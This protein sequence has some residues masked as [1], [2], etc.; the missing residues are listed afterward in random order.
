MDRHVGRVLDALH[1]NGL[2]S[3]TLVIYA[4]DH[5]EQARAHGAWGKISM[6]EDS[7]RVPLLIRGPG[8]AAGRVCRHP[9]SLLDLYPTIGE[10]MGLRPPDF[11]RGASLLD[12]AGGHGDGA[13]RPDHAIAECHLF[14]RAASFAVRQ[15]HWKLI[16]TLGSQPL[17]FNLAEDPGELHDRAG[18]GGVA[19]AA[20]DRLRQRLYGLCDPRVV[21]GRARRDQRARIEQLA[22]S[23]RLQRELAKRGFLMST[24]RLIPDPHASSAA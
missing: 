4:S 15:G 23:G 1:A 8:V 7:L 13:S 6:Y 14:P 16:E 24:S 21:D 19:A 12:L 3:D 20:L 11:A 2:D 22:A 18:A 17:L 10:A 5:G 9:V